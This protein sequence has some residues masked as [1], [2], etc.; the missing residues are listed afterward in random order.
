MIQ[1][2]A[3]PFEVVL[4]YGVVGGKS[5][6]PVAWDPER[7]ALPGRPP[8]RPARPSGGVLLLL[9]SFGALNRALS[10]IASHPEPKEV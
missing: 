4:S 1:V 8:L 3:A 5:D 9:C 10:Q 7:L 6:A 2:S